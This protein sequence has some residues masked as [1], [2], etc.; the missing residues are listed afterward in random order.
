MANKPRSFTEDFLA[1]IKPPTA[2]RDV[3]RDTTVPGL[4]VR[5][6]AAGT[7]TYSL[8]K[9]VGKKPIRFTI[10]EVGAITLKDARS[11]ASVAMGKIP[12]GINPNVEKKQRRAK[13]VTMAQLWD[14]YLTAHA[15]PRKRSWAEDE[16]RYERHM[17]GWANRS[18]ESITSTEIQAL[19]NRVGKDSGHYEA[20]RLRALLH[21]MFAI[22]RHV[23]FNGQN[24]VTGIQRFEEDSRERFLGAEELPQFFTALEKLRVTSPT[25]ADALEL[26]IW[27]G[28]RKGN[29][30]SMVWDELNL[31]QLV[32]IIPGAKHKNGKPVN[33]PL[34]PQAVAIIERRKA[35]TKGQFV[36]PGRRHGKHITDLTKPWK[37]LLDDACLKDVR[38]HDLRRTAGSWM[39]ATG[40]SLPIVGKALGHTS[41]AATQ[42]YA[43]LALDPVRTAVLKATE[44]IQDAKDRKAEQPVKVAS[45]AISHTPAPSSTVPAD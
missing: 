41:T 39:A 44:A 2:G 32:W 11:A 40:A 6:T 22:S 7:K 5:V 30:V 31:E 26:C 35:V 42:I 29:V 38:M 18:L 13:Q 14:Y 21:K 9:K 3:Y 20:N 17:Q 36:F 27:T 15:K 33:V 1:R 37:S 24:P 23:G 16:K 28:A 43:R 25:A 8:Y 10:G 34:V 4:I 45:V 19:H 12:Q